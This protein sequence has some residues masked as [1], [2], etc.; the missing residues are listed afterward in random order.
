[1]K[2]RQGETVL[3]RISV[4]L[5]VVKPSICGQSS[6]TLSR[7]TIRRTIHLKQQKVFSIRRLLSS[8]NF[9]GGNER[10]CATSYDRLHIKLGQ[11]NPNSKQKLA[12]LFCDIWGASLK[13]FFIDSWNRLNFVCSVRHVIHI[14]ADNLF[15][16]RNLLVTFAD[17][18]PT[19]LS[20][21]TLLRPL[22]RLR[23]SCR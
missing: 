11:Y 7:P 14:G 23:A 18:R 9:R 10:H 6:R 5:K 19:L 4:H 1:M 12:Q 15:P 8:L 21:L 13:P 2:N 22:A 20:C 17:E 3:T 16:N